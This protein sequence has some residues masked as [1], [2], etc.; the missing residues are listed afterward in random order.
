MAKPSTEN[1][2]MQKYYPNLSLKATKY[3][4]RVFYG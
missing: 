1:E 3:T 2:Q 4:L